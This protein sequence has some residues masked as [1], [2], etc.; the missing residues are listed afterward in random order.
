MKI[1]F[2]NVN[3]SSRTGPNSFASRLADQFEKMNHDVIESAD[4]QYDIF[5]AFIEPASLP[6]KGSK[7]IHRLD[8]IWF[9]PEQFESH[10]KLIK[11]SYQRADSVICISEFNKNMAAHH[12]GSRDNVKVINNGIEIIPAPVVNKELQSRQL[13]YDNRFICSANWH[14]QKRLKSNIEF[15]KKFRE[16]HPDQN[17]CLAVLGNSPDYVI[18]DR[19]IWYAGSLPHDLC[20][21]LFRDSDWMLHLAWIDHCPNSVVEALSQNCGIVCA[22]SGGTKEIVGN[23][24]VIVPEIEPYAYQLADYD[25]PPDIDISK[26][27]LPE[28]LEIDNSILDIRKIAAR[29]IKVFKDA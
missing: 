19:D 6:R 1:H 14:K 23:N 25:S 27:E 3:F 28:N 11:W 10:N 20:L 4:D 29:Y 16:E 17:S 5:L 2:S 8:G 13:E 12:W 9:K 22:D 7:F 18:E 21:Q 24:G 15:F 26:I